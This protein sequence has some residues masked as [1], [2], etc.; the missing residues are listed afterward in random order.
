M[1]RALLAGF[2]LVLAG[3]SGAAGSVQGFIAS[4]PGVIGS[5]EERV[6]IGVRSLD[7][8]EILGGPDQGLE[9]VLRDEN[10]SPIA[11]LSGEFVW[12]VPE[13]SGLYVVTVDTPGSGTY[14]L[15]LEL[16]GIDSIPPVGLLALDEPVG[17]EV[18]DRAPMSETPTL[19]DRSLSA[20]TSDPEPLAEF[21]ELSLDEAL[22]AGPTVVIFATPAW[23]SSGACGPMLEQVKGFVPAYPTVSFVHV[24]VYEDVNVSDP[25]DLIFSSAVLEWQ[26]PSEPWIFV[27]NSAGTIAASFEGAVADAELTEAIEAVLR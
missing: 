20:L 4:S 26:L 7:T 1:S 5:G 12:V 8:G 13:S 6:L 24:E 17:L 19:D 22:S 10:G 27:V 16:A 11:E 15:D 21:Y 14:Q 18:G 3:C 25:E 9:V 23:C 2:L